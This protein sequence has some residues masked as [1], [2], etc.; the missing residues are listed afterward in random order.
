MD[1]FDAIQTRRSVRRFTAER[2]TPEQVETVL[3]AAMAAP[4]AGNSRPWRF[5]VVDDANLLAKI[6][7]LSPYMGM[8][9]KA[10]LGILVCGDTTVEKH[11]GY[12]VQD[13]SAAIQNML[14]AVTGQGLGAVWCGIHPVA[15]RVQGFKNF[16]ALPEHI[17]PL[18]FVVVGHPENHP[19]PADRYDPAAIHRNGW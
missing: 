4:S 7:S 3:R 5:V 8:A 12:W 1:V 6:P 2:V 10:P 13:C 19:E 16:F 18:G 15:E 14:L 9:D 17:I 11:P